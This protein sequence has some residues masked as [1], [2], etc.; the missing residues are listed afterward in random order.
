MDALAKVC[1]KCGRRYDTAAAFCQKDGLRLELTDEEPD[2][3]IGTTLLDQFKIEERI[4]AGGMGAVYRARQTTLHRDV[5]IKIL[6]PELADNRD[7]VRR[8]KRE[9]RVCTA[10]DHPN[11]VRV[12]LF[13]QLPDGSLYIVMEFLRGRSLLDVIAREGALPVH[14]ALHISTQICA[15]V[16]EAHSQG[17]VHR[18]IKPENI[19]L[20]AKPRDA[21]Y[22]KVLDFGIARVLWGDDQTQATQS[23][24]VFGTARYISPEGAAGEATDARSDVYSLGVLTYQL[25]CGETPFDAPSPV[26]MLM[27]HIHA[28]PPHLLSHERAK[29][30]PEP[31]ADVIMRALAKNAEGRY[32]DAN[33]FGEALCAA[34]EGSGFQLVGLRAE[35][36]GLH[37]GLIA[38]ARRA[39]S[40]ISSAPAKKSEG[41]AVAVRPLE[42]TPNE[43]AA[44]P[45]ERPSKR[46]ARKE[47]KS[48]PPPE[49]GTLTGAPSP[50]DE[51]DDVSIPGLSLPKLAKPQP[52]R[53]LVVAGAFV[54]GIGLVAG[55]FAVAGWVR[56][57]GDVEELSELDRARADARA[58]FR[59]G[60]YDEP[61]E[62]SVLELTDRILDAEPDDAEAERLRRQSADRLAHD[63]AAAAARGDRDAAR[64]LY[65]RALRFRPGDTEITAAIA[66]LTEPATPEALP[67][68]RARPVSVVEGRAITLVAVLQPGD[69]AGARAEP[70]FVIRRAGESRNTTVF[71]AATEEPRTFE[72]QHTFPSPGSYEVVFRLGSGADRIEMTA[73]IEVARDP[74]RPSRPRPEREPPP[75]TTQGS[76][77][78]PPTIAPAWTNQPVVPN[79]PPPP[80]PDPPPPSWGSVL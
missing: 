46:E 25:L 69:E 71:A 13:G 11:V 78:S 67:G 40:D 20:V 60:H 43:P 47:A 74:A 26:A 63:A 39:P 66:E 77:W 72:A 54:V 1:P 9:A 8:F 31:V 55:G 24:L 14:R 56:D 73:T 36:S 51:A 68:V 4:G 62:G 76:V 52:R 41:A 50:F 65:E 30:V 70:R 10:L 34:A 57:G 2:P 37:T 6:H 16:G 32:D 58:A 23:G 45:T 61:R 53:W 7:A 19:V 22:V 27:K 48:E 35:G 28:T 18:D 29:H 80:Q 15:G 42:P 21:D 33:T 12:F 49:S 17:V 5:A 59:S 38:N 75:V 64:A 3:Y 44:E 79:E